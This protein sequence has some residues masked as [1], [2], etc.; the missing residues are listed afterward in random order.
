MIRNYPHR[1]SKRQLWGYC[2]LMAVKAA[3]V[4][5]LLIGVLAK[6][7]QANE[8]DLKKVFPCQID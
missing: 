8:V 5:V 2:Y 3:Q 1:G 4:T 7:S 6:S